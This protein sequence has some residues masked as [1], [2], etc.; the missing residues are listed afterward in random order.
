MSDPV[1]CQPIGNLE[2]YDWH[3]MSVHVEVLRNGGKTLLITSADALNH[4]CDGD[5]DDDDPEL[6]HVPVI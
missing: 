5:V 1:L 6:A 2:L 4:A 3:F